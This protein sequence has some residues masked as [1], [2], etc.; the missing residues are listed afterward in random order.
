M[1]HQLMFE[2]NTITY[3]RTLSTRARAIRLAVYHDGSCK[4]TTPRHVREDFVEKFLNE[5][6]AWIYE[7][8]TH[9]KNNPRTVLGKGTKKELNV[10]KEAVHTLV[11]ERL[12]HFNQH[13]KTKWNK[14]TIRNQSSRWGSCSKQGNLSFNYK[15]IDIPQALSDYIIVHELCHLKEMNHSANFWKLVEQTIPDYKNRRKLLKN[16]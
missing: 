6:A 4:L 5:K 8:V 2:G 12:L 10:H 9:F 3:T 11:M 7:K 15:L 13:Y 1:Q 16:L 14:I